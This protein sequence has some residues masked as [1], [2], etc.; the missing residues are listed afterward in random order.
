MRPFRRFRDQAVPGEQV[1]HIMQQLLV[2]RIHGCHTRGHRDICRCTDHRQQLTHRVLQ[3]PAHPIACHSFTDSL[4]N[5]EP[6][7]YAL[8]T[9]Q[10]TYRYA[11]GGLRSAMGVALSEIA[12]AT[13]PLIPGKHWRSPPHKQELSGFRSEMPACV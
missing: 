10:H 4:A 12:A 3:S 2:G 5:T 9:P 6:H 7:T 1:S 13:Q 11:P 8:F